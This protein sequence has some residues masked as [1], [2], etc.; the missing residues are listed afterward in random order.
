LPSQNTNVQR[1]KLAAPALNLSC[2]GLVNN[3]G[4]IITTGNS[5]KKKLEEILPKYEVEM[6]KSVIMN[7]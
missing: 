5:H 1:L 7:T 6:Q 2:P 4:E 3:S